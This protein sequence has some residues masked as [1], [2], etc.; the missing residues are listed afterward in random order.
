MRN[1]VNHCDLCESSDFE[2]IARRDRDG[3]PLATC[4]CRS[5][6]LVRHEEIP[7]EEELS[8][9][10]AHAYRKAYHGELVPSARR[11][12]RAWR[13]GQRILKQISPHLPKESR[14]FEV[15]AGIGC[16][17]KSFEFAGF[18]ASGIDPGV[19]FATFAR[20]ELRASV[21]VADLFQL[22]PVPAFDAVLLVHVIEHFRSPRRALEAIRKLL[23][24]NGRLYVECPNLAAPFA[25]RA[26]L[27][28]VAHIHNFTP[29]TLRQLAQRCGYRVEETFSTADDP[30]LQM[31][32]VRD[33]SPR[34][35]DDP[36]SYGVTMSA[37]ER[38]ESLMYHLNK[39]YL[40]RRVNKVAAYLGE[41][42]FA[43]QR[44]ERLLARCR[45][46]AGAAYSQAKAA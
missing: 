38:S 13:N 16:T 2:V 37:I 44:V 26:K 30:N 45:S 36:A 15:G 25:T 14:V 43:K 34:V 17:V 40:R 19:G 33:E 32:L 21:Q 7:T 22:P 28:H 6:G 24:R 39:N 29:N 46:E 1:N 35:I 20:K 12:D 5:C 23:A 11:V 9:F 18:R 42:L 3:E 8:D 31:L 10:Y 4:V 41:H 27:F